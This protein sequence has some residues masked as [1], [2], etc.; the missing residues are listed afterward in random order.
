MQHGVITKSR[1]TCNYASFVHVIL[2]HVKMQLIIN[3]RLRYICILVKFMN[4]MSV[5][6][7]LPLFFFFSLI[8]IFSNPSFLFI[9]MCVCVCRLRCKLWVRGSISRSW[10]QSSL[11]WSRS[12][13]RTSIPYVTLSKRWLPLE[14]HMLLGVGMRT[15]PFEHSMTLCGHSW[16]LCRFNTTPFRLGTESRRLKFLAGWRRAQQH[17][18]IVKGRPLARPQMPTPWSACLGGQ[19]LPRVASYS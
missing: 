2:S 12:A 10:S 5:W 14:I 13:K 8:I 6:P 19:A 11:A 16:L 7:C 3:K 17:M 1:E 9:Y 4:S 15:T 18:V